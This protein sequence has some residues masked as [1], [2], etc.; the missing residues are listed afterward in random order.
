MYTVY[1]IYKSTSFKFHYW[2]WK[3]AVKLLARG[4]LTGDVSL[5]IVQYR[6]CCLD[7]RILNFDIIL[8]SKTQQRDKRD[9]VTQNRI[10]FFFL[11]MTCMVLVQKK[12]VYTY[13]QICNNYYFL[14]NIFNKYS[15]NYCL[16]INLCSLGLKIWL[17]IDWQFGNYWISNEQRPLCFK[18]VVS[19]EYRTFDSQQQRERKL[20]PLMKTIR[21]DW[22]QWNIRRKK[23]GP[24]SAY[25]IWSKL[26]N[27]FV[28][29]IF[30]YLNNFDKQ[31][32]IIIQRL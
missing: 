21:Y 5:N 23:S 12:S 27:T 8:E 26:R 17:T 6:W 7:T 20:H 24:R 22:K 2:P 10:F 16:V 18:H 32:D 14:N 1:V 19:K 9:L 29:L 15:N 11:L 30:I 31:S 4:P 13:K 28:I 3:Y 25:S